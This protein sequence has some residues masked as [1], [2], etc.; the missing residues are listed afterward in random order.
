M[1]LVAD[2]MGP[3]ATVEVDLI[4]IYTNTKYWITPDPCK[5]TSKQIRRNCAYSTFNVCP[6]PPFNT[7]QKLFI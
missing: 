7:V 6:P 1:A 2:T 4:S 5:Y 3:M